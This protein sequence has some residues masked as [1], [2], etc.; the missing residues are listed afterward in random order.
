LLTGIDPYAE[1]TQTQTMQAAQMERLC[2]PE[3]VD[4]RLATLIRGLTLKA[5]EDRWEYEEVLRWCNDEDVEVKDHTQPIKAYH[6]DGK[7]IRDLNDLAIAIAQNWSEGIKHMGR[8]L[9][10][11]HFR[12]I[13]QDL[14]SKIS[15]CD[16]LRPQDLGLMKLIYCLKPDAPLYWRGEMLVD[17]PSLGV[18]ISKELPNINKN[19]LE[20]LT[21]GA[22]RT[23]LEIKGFDLN[24]INTIKELEIQAATE[25]DL[26]Y[27]RLA[28]LLN[29]NSEFKYHNR[30]FSNPDQLVAYLY[31]QRSKI[32][33]IANE[34]LE[35]KDFL[36]W[37]THLGFGEKIAGWQKISYE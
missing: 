10:F 34:L 31:E 23:F 4:T 6:F 37:L 24:L 25:P 5:P 8:G 3:T 32:N 27:F 15:D 19:Y 29:N 35:N 28:R 9:L 17:L 1:M 20:L 33:A 36:A 11:E 22:L 30:S 16:E 18:S 21:L 14:A 7:E 2:I 12:T 26:A 13:N